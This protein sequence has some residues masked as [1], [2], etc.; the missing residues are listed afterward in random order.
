VRAVLDVNVFIS[1][2]LAPEGTAAQ[3][4]LR[5]LHGE[6]ELVISDE[7]LAEL[8]RALTYPELRTRISEQ[9]TESLLNLLRRSTTVTA[10]PPSPAPATSRDPGDDYL[11]A[12]AAA[13]GS[14]LVSWDQDLLELT[15]FPI[16]SP[17]QFLRALDEQ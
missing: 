6:F 5:W 10:A 4:L 11:V 12:L 3:L 14:V 15:G 9:A 13:T 17:P 8:A 16:Q 1:G 7:L 2:V